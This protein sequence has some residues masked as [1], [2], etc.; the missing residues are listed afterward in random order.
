MPPDK[1][2][3][4]NESEVNDNNKKKRINLPSSLDEEW[5]E[6][7]IMNPAGIKTVSRTQNPPDAEQPRF[8]FTN[9]NVK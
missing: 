6:I 8:L 5:R 2:R 7:S 4:M 3:V 9:G 1:F